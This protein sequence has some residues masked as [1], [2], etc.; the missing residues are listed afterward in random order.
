MAAPKESTIRLMT[1]LAM[2]H[3]ATNLSQG[4]PN[5]APPFEM[6]RCAPLCATYVAAA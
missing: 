4:F 6:V 2:E 5:E 3:G 1:R